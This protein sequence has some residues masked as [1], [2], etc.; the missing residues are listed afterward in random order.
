MAKNTGVISSDEIDIRKIRRDSRPAYVRFHAW[1]TDPAN[2]LFILGSMATLLVL[3]PA[4]LV[5]VFL[6]YVILSLMLSGL[7][8][9][10]PVRVPINA[11]TTDFSEPNPERKNKFL[12][13]KGIFYLGHDRSPEGNQEQVF[14]SDSDARTHFFALGTTGSGKTQALLSWA[15]NS[16]SWGSSFI[17]IDGKAD[18]NLV[19]QSYAMCRRV[20]RE[21]D[22]FV[23]NFTTGDRDA[24]E[25]RREDKYNSNTINPF[26]VGSANALTQLVSSLMPESGG[27]NAMWQGLAIG[28]VNAVIN[29]LCYK[30]FQ[31]GFTIDAGILRDYI[32]LSM[33]IKLTR[34]FDSRSD[35]PKD[36]VFKPLKT[37]LM[38]LPGFDW[39]IN[40]V[41]EQPVSEDTKKQ[42]DF[43]SMQ[44]LRQLT[45]LA[46][47]YGSV[48]KA[49]IPEVDMLDVVLKRRIVIVCIPSLEKSEEESQGVGKLVI[50]SIKLM[51]AK[52]LGADV[53]GDYDDA[54]GSKP[55]KS[56]SPFVAI[57]DE[58]GY[59]FTKGLAAMFAQARGLGFALFAAGQD[60]SAMMK[61]S[62]KE[63]AES[64]VAN[65]K[66]KISLAMEDPERTADLIIKTAGKAIVSEVA[67]YEGKMGSVTSATY[68]DNLNATI[69]ERNRL[70]LEE[71]R[72]MDSGESVLL[73]RDR[74]I[75]M[76]NFYVFSGPGAIGEGGSHRLNQLLSCFC[77]G[78]DEIMV[79]AKELPPIKKDP[80][81]SILSVLL[82]GEPAETGETDDIGDQI[83]VHSL[84]PLNLDK[85]KSGI[86]TELGIYYRF[87]ELFEETGKGTHSARRRSGSGPS[88]NPSVQ[89][90][91]MDA[92]ATPVIEE[93]GFR[94]NFEKIFT[95][96]TE[97]IY[98][99]VPVLNYSK[100]DLAVD[101][102]NGKPTINE[103]AWIVNLDPE[104]KTSLE[105]LDT[106]LESRESSAESITR[107]LNYQAKP[108][109]FLSREL[110]EIGPDFNSKKSGFI[111]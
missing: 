10:M 30:R 22:F 48:F 81:S 90:K 1:C 73:W 102:V 72:D 109:G 26:A 47:T 89:R 51:M 5:P 76:Q 69:Q 63:E 36:L 93:T 84:A 20:A 70:T 98:P 88:L 15:F 74:I 33:L 50:S 46:D 12:N 57:F 9:K 43:R 16:L 60:L 65:T 29:G 68:K 27:D 66:F 49:Q 53:E 21:D 54:V 35:A 95:E 3:V 67:G 79:A 94:I 101:F 4:L 2:T 61:G 56:K 111:A 8:I 96:D 62:N 92:G 77:P 28:M 108:E 80:V 38:N 11:N 97:A 86:E 41:R 45:M 52:T 87:R 32:E 85:N 17:Y 23:I 83:I 75:R 6:L 105:T 59:Y 107:T 106:L 37:Y 44:F 34:E 99:V 42:H 64:V 39:E 24:F 91:S 13:G 82:S 71:L 7:K 40:L 14:A 25:L 55:T 19:Y 78:K 31:D 110:H 104:T 58:L 103:T 18:N 100:L